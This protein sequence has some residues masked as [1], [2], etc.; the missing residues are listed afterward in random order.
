MVENMS[1]DI[2]NAFQDWFEWYSDGRDYGFSVRYWK[3]IW[4]SSNIFDIHT[5][6]DGMSLEFGHD[7]YEVMCVIGDINNF[8]YI[9]DELNY[10]KYLVVYQ[11]LDNFNLVECGTSV[12]G[13]WF[14]TDYINT[15]AYG[16]VELNELFKFLED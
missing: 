12:R 9:K 8:D 15:E 1:F 3:F 6:D 4:F 13:A 11:L 7:I 10:K 14:G 2:E 16:I 5:D